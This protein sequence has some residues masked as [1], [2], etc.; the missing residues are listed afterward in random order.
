MGYRKDL[1]TVAQRAAEEDALHR[2]TG[3]VRLD[4]EVPR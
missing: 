4:V 3:R 1:L 2:V